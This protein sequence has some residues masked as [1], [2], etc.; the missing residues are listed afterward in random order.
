MSKGKQKAWRKGAQ[1]VNTLRVAMGDYRGG[2]T[3]KRARQDKGTA[4]SASK[5]VLG[6]LVGMPGT[7]RLSPCGYEAPGRR[8]I[9]GAKTV[10]VDVET[11]TGPYWATTEE[12]NV[13][14]D[15]AQA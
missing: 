10:A 11:H 12:F 5:G 2:P 8:T 13:S 7:K 15:G 6:A 4:G 3:I 14:A 1:V 9:P